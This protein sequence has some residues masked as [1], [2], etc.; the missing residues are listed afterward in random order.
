MLLIAPVLMSASSFIQVKTFT[1]GF[2][3]TDF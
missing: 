1:M 3:S 2:P